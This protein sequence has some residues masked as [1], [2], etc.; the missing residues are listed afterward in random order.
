MYRYSGFSLTIHSQLELPELPNGGGHPD[1]TIRLGTVNPPHRLATI[2][3]EVACPRN[4][5]RFRITSGTEIMVDLLPGV[6]AGVLRTMLEGPLMAYL[7]R[8]RGYLPLHASAVAIAGQGVLF[9]GESGAGKSTTAAAFSVRGHDVLAD[10]LA[11]VRIEKS[12]IALETAGCG[13]RLLEDSRKVIG[14]AAKSTGLPGGKHFCSLPRRA[15][16]G[17]CA[18]KRIYLLDYE[19]CDY[20]PPVRSSELCRFSAAALLNGRSFLRDWRAGDALRQINL[21]RSAALAAARTVCRLIRPRSLHLL[22]TLVDFVEKDMQR[23][24]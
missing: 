22:P 19:D 9:L 2:D 13:L 21:D 1:V 10:D 8:Q 12:A 24:D 18:L 3:D 14:A 5:G 15:C 6:D 17:S 4:I 16:G 20:A 23:N 11:A 7:L